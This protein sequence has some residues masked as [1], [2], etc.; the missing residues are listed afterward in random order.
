M[1]QY[2]QINP[3]QYRRSSTPSNPRQT[4][5]VHD[6]RLHH[7]ET[8]R[9]Q[10]KRRRGKTAERIQDPRRQNTITNRCTHGNTKNQKPREPRRNSRIQIKANRSAFGLHKTN[11]QEQDPNRRQ[12]NLGNSKSSNSRNHPRNHRLHSHIT[13][14]RRS[15]SPRR[16][17]RRAPILSP[18]RNIRPMGRGAADRSQQTQNRKQVAAIRI[19]HF[20]HHHSSPNPP[21]RST[22]P[23]APSHSSPYRLPPASSVVRIV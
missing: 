11:N 16:R 8:Y 21:Y 6:G 1:D 10:N 14:H 20:N 4:T 18:S 9:Q 15:R 13:S 23:P 22:T 5:D 12:R 3:H 17:K 7:L 19:I 2:A